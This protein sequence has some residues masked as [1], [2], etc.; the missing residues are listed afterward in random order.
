MLRLPNG[1]VSG[2]VWTLTASGALST[3]DLVEG[4]KSGRVFVSI[5]S[6]NYPAGELRGAVGA[7]ADLEAL[8]AMIVRFAEHSEALALRLALADLPQLLVGALL[9]LLASCVCG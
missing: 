4:I 3:T 1:Q 5:E 8:R 6:A 2:Q 7:A 9:L